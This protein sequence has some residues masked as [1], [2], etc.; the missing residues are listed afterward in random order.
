M[1]SKLRAVVF[2]S[3][4]GV[5][6]VGTGSAFAESTVGAP[7]PDENVRE[8]A[9][10]QASQQ[11]ETV[12]SRPRPEYDPLGLRYEGFYFYPK[13][14]QTEMFDDNIFAVPGAG[15]ADLISIFSP[16]F[17]IR[18]DFNQHAVSFGG[19]ADLGRYMIS[20]GE[21]YDDWAFFGDGRIDVTREAGLVGAATFARRHEDRGSPDN[22]NGKHPTEFYAFAP[23]VGGYWQL[24]RFSIRAETGLT[25]YDYED[26]ATSQGLIIDQDDRD[27]TEYTGGARFGYEIVPNYEAFFRGAYNNRVYNNKTDG[28]GFRRSNDG[29]EVDVGTAVDLTGVIFGNVFAGYRE[30]YYQ[31]SRLPSIKGPGFG[32]DVTWNVTKLTTVKALVE[33]RTEETTLVGASGYNSMNFGASV[34]HELM[35]N[36]LLSASGSYQINDYKGI[37]RNDDLIRAGAGG[38]YLINRYA[39]IGLAYNFLNR[40]SNVPGENFTINQV[41]LT[42]DL[43]M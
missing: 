24:N 25:R 1:N 22:V 31:D 28:D 21:N 37:D 7:F 35:R 34:D 32:A 40:N 36:I 12:T 2:A 13:W 5:A 42:L 29:W 10:A 18:S 16:A 11:R 6:I 38:K 15:K 33:R 41:L 19:R 26:V 20:P 17:Q 8:G 14:T 27:R 3:V 4:A 43:Q 30:Q 39:A 9:A 23:S